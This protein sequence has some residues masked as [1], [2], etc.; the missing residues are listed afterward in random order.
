MLSTLGSIVQDTYPD[1]NTGL[2][3][4]VK[5]GGGV[6][7]HAG[8]DSDGLGSLRT[9]TEDEGRD[10]L[11]ASPAPDYD[12]VELEMGFRTSRPSYEIPRQGVSGI[13]IDVEKASSSTM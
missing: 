11:E 13:R 12:A 3:R 7:M 5:A 10:K 8:D 1:I 9:R 4:G 6:A 2:A